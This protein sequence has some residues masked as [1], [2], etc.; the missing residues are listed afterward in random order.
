MLL[1]IAFVCLAHQKCLYLIYVRIYI[2]TYIYIYIYIYCIYIYMNRN[3]YLHIHSI[4]ISKKSWS[5]AEDIKNHSSPTMK[6]P[7]ADDYLQGIHPGRLTWNIT[8]EVWKIIFLSK[9][10]ISRFHVNLPG[11][12][13]QKS[14]SP[15]IRKKW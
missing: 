12:T 5:N 11:Y 8:M 13:L 14:I 3:L 2:Y 7:Y 4:I 9:W 1:A 15:S 10:L 6:H